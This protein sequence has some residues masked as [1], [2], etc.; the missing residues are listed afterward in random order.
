MP[1]CRINCLT[2]TP[3]LYL[4]LAITALAASAAQPQLQT[5][6][7]LANNN[8]PVLA[9]TGAETVNSKPNSMI[10]RCEGFNCRR[11]HEL[12]Y[13]GFD[14]KI[15]FLSVHSLAPT[16]DPLLT[17]SAIS[18]IRDERYLL[19]D[20]YYQ[21][22]YALDKYAMG[23]FPNGWYRLEAR[24]IRGYNYVASI[25]IN[26]A[27]NAE[28]PVDRYYPID[29]AT[30]QQPVVNTGA[31]ARIFVDN[32]VN[33]NIDTVTFHGHWPDTASVTR[34]SYRDPLACATNPNHCSW[35]ENPGSSLAVDAANNV[36][37]ADNNDFVDRIVAR[38]PDGELKPNINNVSSLFPCFVNEA[39][40]SMAPEENVL[41]LPAGCQS[42]TAGG[43]ARLDT[44]GDGNHQLTAV[45]YY[46]QGLIVDWYDQ[47]RAFN[48][49][50]DFAGNYDPERYLYL[51]L[52][53]DGQLIATLPVMADYERG[54]LN[55][56][57]FNPYTNML[58][59]A[60]NTTIYQVKVNYGG[61]AGFPPLPEGEIVITPGAAQDLIAGDSSAVFHFSVGAVNQNTRVSYRELPP[62]AVPGSTS[63]PTAIT[64]T[65]QYTMRQFELTAVTSDTNTPLDNFNSNYQLKL[66]YSPGEIGPI[67]GGHNNV[68]LYQWVGSSWQQVGFTYGSGIDNILYISTNLTGRFA[69]LGP[70][71]NLHLPLVLK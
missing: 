53:Y 24:I 12:I 37:I 29:G 66:Y 42:F 49:T 47:K 36:Y 38:K 8:S 60:V 11:Y 31:L 14:N 3:I 20:R 41:Y 71:N 33:G 25:P 10:I 26:E 17:S 39:G 62:T 58:Y 18:G 44:T 52:L 57:A 59:L 67:I 6:A 51:H 1:A 30:L 65:G 15:Y 13:W 23:S 5:A 9:L 55:A 64:V 40:I 35:Q 63:L 56:M 34:F 22:L 2:T 70:T 61:S 32:P 21:Q 27:V 50:T 4:L 19:Y 28:S 48:A 54:S 43:V 16:A 46:D 69:I 7:L 45:P 68:Q